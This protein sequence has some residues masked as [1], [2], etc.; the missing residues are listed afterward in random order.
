MSIIVLAIEQPR[1]CHIHRHIPSQVPRTPFA[2]GELSEGEL[3]AE[4]NIIYT[5]DLQE[6]RI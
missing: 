3:L 1:H 5:Y 2:S 4:E 6:T